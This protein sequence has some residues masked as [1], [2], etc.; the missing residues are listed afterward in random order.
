MIEGALSNKSE[1]LTSNCLLYL[2]KVSER[3]NLDEQ[4]DPYSYNEPQ[5]NKPTMDFQIDQMYNKF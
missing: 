1:T 3:M 5:N 2:L 4:Q